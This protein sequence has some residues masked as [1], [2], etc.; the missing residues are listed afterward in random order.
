MYQPPRSVS[1]SLRW[2][3]C[4]QTPA[5]E[6]ILSRDENGCEQTPVVPCSTGY[7]G[8]EYIKLSITRSKQEYTRF[9]SFS[10]R[11]LRI[12]RQRFTVK[13][14][15]AFKLHYTRMGS[16]WENLGESWHWIFLSFLL[17]ISHFSSQLTCRSNLF[18][19]SIYICMYVYL[20]ITDYILKSSGGYQL[21]KR[22]GG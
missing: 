21:Y 5:T 16:Q 19:E 9:F 7:Q 8:W 20:I 3:G 2:N 4:E 17:M 11:H 6:C 10:L 13:L 1:I 15:L 22:S 18:C 14:R 12:F